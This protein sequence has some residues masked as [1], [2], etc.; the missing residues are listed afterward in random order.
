M[1]TANRYDILTQGAQRAPSTKRHDIANLGGQFFTTKRT[2]YIARHYRA[3]T[4]NL[5][6]IRNPVIHLIVEQDCGKVT[7]TGANAQ[8]Y[9]LLYDKQPLP[10]CLGLLCHPRMDRQSNQQDV[11]ASY[12]PDVNN[13]LELVS[14]ISRPTKA[15]RA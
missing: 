7:G 12:L 6:L 15:G 11:I 3:T 8:P 1:L 9:D 2:G 10:T 5:T 13:R 4:N 14:I